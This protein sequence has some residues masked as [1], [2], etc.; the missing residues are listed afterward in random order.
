MKTSLIAGL[1]AIAIAASAF[2]Q[3]RVDYKANL[4]KVPAKDPAPEGTPP[5]IVPAM[6]GQHPR[7][8]FTTAEIDA[9]RKASETDPV[10]KRARADV[11][12]WAR[13]FK[14]PKEDPPAIV[15]N[16]TQAL[17]TACERYAGLAYAYAL[18]KDPNAKQAILDILNMMLD[19]P[20]WADAPELDSNMGA[21]NNMVMVGLLFDTIA[22]DLDA[23][24]R[25]KLVDKML[26]HVRRMHYLGHKQLAVK[27]IKYWQQDPQNNHRWH[28]MA[29]VSAC[30][31]A[32]Y[33]EPGVDAG[34]L[35]DYYKKEMDFLTKWFPHDG[36]CHE[37]AGYQTFG[38]MY[39]GMAATIWD[40]V[41]GSDYLKS[42]AGF[43]NAANQQLYYNAPGRNGNQS[44]GD[45]MNGD[46]G[47]F[48]H[49][50]AAFFLSARLT[51]NKDL[52]A[53]LVDR[54]ERYM[55]RKDGKP[56]Q[57]P[58]GLFAFYDPTLAK[59]NADALP[60]YRLFPDLGAASIRDKWTDDGVLLTFKCGPYGGY[61]LNDYR[62]TVMGPDGKP[63]YINVAHDDPDANTFALGT[64]GDF[65][66]HPG[67]YSFQKI[68][69][70][71]NGVTVNGKG[72]I[73]E[74]SDYTQP[75]KDTDMRTLS[76]L[77]GWKADDKGRV[78]VEGEAGKAYPDLKAF[79]RTAVYLP[80][81]Y[82]LL[83][84]DIRGDAQNEITWRG[85]VE[86]GNF[87]KPETGHCYV[88]T[89]SGKRMDFQI[90]ANQPFTGALDH[91]YLDGRFG[92]KL[93]QQFQFAAR[94]DAV[95]FACL[96]DPWKKKPE[97]TLAEQGGTTTL[98]I[99]V[100]GKTDTWTWATASD[101]QTPS[102]IEGKRGGEALIT[103]TP[104]D[105]APHGD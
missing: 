54:L 35:L 75:V 49:H 5:Q 66:F 76:Y 33:D 80:G 42:T 61:A 83:L 105:K 88:E 32:I 65:L 30:L 17:A 96:M 31:L 98:S 103:L 7:L 89:K 28:R 47:N 36:D 58:W 9:M 2:G 37:G 77:T 40:R 72:Q 26:T 15:T 91:M 82:I 86:K 45:D 38:F 102:S 85:T 94:T 53:A 81:E 8:M 39:L 71:N 59:G 57:Y 90:L 25:K 64:G 13:R 21:G 62:H 84:D 3:A 27:T 60:P 24:L 100:E 22:G 78:I 12:G 4:A 55:N 29:G 92:G 104:A 95:R 74:G 20:Y 1:A 70:T 93:M 56:T 23:S 68:T 44:F 16:D 18:D 101:A 43:A 73:G 11:G 50:A 14:L 48:N 34:Y 19:Q 69:R 52:Q 97:M 10:L 79:R 63:H 41:T 99:T 67:L 87:E 46:N 6:R 51:R